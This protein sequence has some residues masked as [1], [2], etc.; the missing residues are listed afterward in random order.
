MPRLFT[1]IGDLVLNLPELPI[2]SMKSFGCS[3]CVIV[4]S[5]RDDCRVRVSAIVASSVDT[6]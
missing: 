6:R 4:N 1:G 5:H 3:V 2:C